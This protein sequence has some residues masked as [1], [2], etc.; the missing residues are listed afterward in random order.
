MMILCVYDDITALPPTYKYWLYDVG[1]F[2]RYRLGRK[3]LHMDV[4]P[5]GDLV[6]YADECK[7]G[8]N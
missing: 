5:S 3:A 8:V 2:T 1:Q 4:S 7:Q 6:A